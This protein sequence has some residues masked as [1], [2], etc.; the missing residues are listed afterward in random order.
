[1]RFYPGQ[2]TRFLEFAKKEFENLGYTDIKVDEKRNLIV[3]DASKAKIV[4]TAHYDTPPL[5]PY[6]TPFTRIF[7]HLIGSLI[8]GLGIFIALY[9]LTEWFWRQIDIIPGLVDWIRGDNQPGFWEQAMPHIIPIITSVALYALTF[10]VPNPNNA[11]DNTSGVLGV[12]HT[13]MLLRRLNRADDVAFVLFNLEELGLIG[14]THFRETHKGAKFF[15]INYDML[16]VGEIPLLGYRNN[17][18]RRLARTLA[19]THEGKAKHSSF[20]TYASDNTVFDNSLL[21]AGVSRSMF[22]ATYAPGIHLPWDSK[23][24]YQL[25]EK[26]CNIGIEAGDL[27][28]QELSNP[29]SI[30]SQG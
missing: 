4:Y 30:E 3:G 25:I 21:V 28:L 7:G 1:M 10:L 27:V 16:G 6:I 8:G 20:F 12:L 19:D 13:A 22:G 5:S 9:F 26:Y 15:L 18:S 17:K 11:N 23:V 2:K 14:S 24:D 29:P